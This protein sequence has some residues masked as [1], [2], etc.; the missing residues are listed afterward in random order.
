[1]PAGLSLDGTAGEISGI[2][3]AE[4]IQSFTVEVTDNEGATDT[5]DLSINVNAEGGTFS[6]SVSYATEGGRNGDKHLLITFTAS[7]ANGTVS[8]VT[9]AIPC[10][11]IRRVGCGAPSPVPPVRMER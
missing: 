7:D 11:T 1:M 5:Q 8:G 6:L 9:F 10:L 4:G 3:T 2:L